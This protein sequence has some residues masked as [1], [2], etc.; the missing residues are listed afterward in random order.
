MTIFKNGTLVWVW[1]NIFSISAVRRQVDICKIKLSLV[2]TAS[3]KLAWTT[4]QT[5]T[6][7][8]L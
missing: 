2:Y 1:R 7:G 3:S 4:G 8:T 6:K 5:T